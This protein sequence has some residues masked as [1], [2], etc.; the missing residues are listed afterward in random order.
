[1]KRFIE[2]DDDQKDGGQL[3]P[4]V[5]RVKIFIPNC[6]VLRNGVCLVDLPGFGD[7]NAARHDISAEVILFSLLRVFILLS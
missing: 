7:S 3:W 4:I 2:N 6:A 1:M 5:K